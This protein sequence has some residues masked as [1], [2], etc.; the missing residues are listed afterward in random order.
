MINKAI[1]L[2][3][4][5][6]K[7]YRKTQK[8]DY[9]TLLSVATNRRWK[10]KEGVNKTITN[11]HN[12]NFFNKL[13][14]IANNY[15]EVGSMVYIEGEINNKKIDNE[16]GKSQWVYSIIAKE[17]EVISPRKKPIENDF[18]TEN[19]LE[20]NEDEDFNFNM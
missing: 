17:I 12:V 9:M 7:V 18:N 5:G 15:A 6:K 20:E 10:T 3:R 11:W 13:A 16:Q 19:L 1:L 14:D 2:G 8:G 4:V